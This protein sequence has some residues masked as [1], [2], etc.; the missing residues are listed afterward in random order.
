[1][2]SA[3]QMLHKVISKV[4][5]YVFVL[6]T[7]LL[8]DLNSLPLKATAL[9]LLSLLLIV[10]TKLT[11]CSCLVPLVTPNLSYSCLVGS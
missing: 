2:K 5:K 6:Y 10:T 4:V 3:Q 7:Y 11:R 1:M 9:S 8:L